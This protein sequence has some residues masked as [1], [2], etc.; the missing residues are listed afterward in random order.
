MIWREPRLSPTTPAFDL[1]MNSRHRA[2][3]ALGMAPVAT[4]IQLGRVAT[5]IDMIEILQAPWIADF[6]PLRPRNGGRGVEPMRLA[7]CVLG[8]LPLRAASSLPG[9]TNSLPGQ[10]IPCVRME[11]GIG[12]KLLNPLC[13]RLP[14]PCQKARIVRTLRKLPANFPADREFGGPLPGER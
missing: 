3:R 10:K 1:A 6:R 4:P 2:P 14:K 5:G 9:R 11:Q 13:D 7:R 12:C 8:T